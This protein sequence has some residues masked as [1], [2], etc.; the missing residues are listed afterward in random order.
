M[1]FGF[2]VVQEIDGSLDLKDIGRGKADVDDALG[3]FVAINWRI[4]EFFD[5]GGRYTFIDYEL[6]G[7]SNEYDG[8]NIAIVAGFTF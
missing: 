7:F 2:G 4:S 5:L 3:K 6:T 1:S 8:N